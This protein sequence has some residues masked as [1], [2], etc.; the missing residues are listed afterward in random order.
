MSYNPNTGLVYF[1]F[2][3]T[4]TFY[5]VDTNFNYRRGG[6]RNTGILSQQESRRQPLKQGVVAWDPVANRDIWRVENRTARGTLSSGGNLVFFT[7]D[8]RLHA[9][10][11]RTGKTLWSAFVGGGGTPVTFELDGRQYVAVG[12]RGTGELPR[13]LAFVLDGNPIPE[14]ILT[15]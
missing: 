3:N 11:G 4:E 1:T 5:S 12:V 9:H 13:V 6:R 15:K 10:D 14:P 8:N 7:A 2:H